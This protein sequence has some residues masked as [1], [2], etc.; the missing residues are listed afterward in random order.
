MF[1]H[2]TSWCGALTAKNVLFRCFKY[3]RLTKKVQ[4]FLFYILVINLNW[5]TIFSKHT[6]PLL[7]IDNDELAWLNDSLSV[8]QLWENTPWKQFLI[9]THGFSCLGTSE[10]FTNIYVCSL[11]NAASWKNSTLAAGNKLCLLIPT[12]P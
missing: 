6:L 1:R 7:S 3:T 2:S 10:I 5:Y 4:S 8:H 12:L 11:L 9:I